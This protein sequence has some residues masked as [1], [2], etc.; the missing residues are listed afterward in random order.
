M[1]V[2]RQRMAI[3]TGM[4]AIGLPI[5]AAGATGVGAA[6]L[7]GGAILA[8]LSFLFRNST[9]H[10]IRR[11]IAPLDRATTISLGFA[12]VTGVAIGALVNLAFGDPVEQNLIDMGFA[13]SCGQIISLTL[14]DTEEDPVV[15]TSSSSSAGA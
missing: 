3:A 10:Y 9:A 5:L 2:F 12:F 8:L 1:I 11:E 14:I 7:V 6:F 13:L 4:A 15:G